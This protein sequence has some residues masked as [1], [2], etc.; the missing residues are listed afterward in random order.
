[1]KEWRSLEL[2]DVFL[3]LVVERHFAD[4]VL[5]ADWNLAVVGDALTGALLVLVESHLLLIDYAIHVVP[6]PARQIPG[7]NISFFV[8][9]V[10]QTSF[11]PAGDSYLLEAF[12]LCPSHSCLR[13]RKPSSWDV[14]P[15]CC[16]FAGRVAAWLPLPLRDAPGDPAGLG[17][18]TPFTVSPPSTFSWK[19]RELVGFGSRWVRCRRLNQEGRSCSMQNRITGC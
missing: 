7:S 12:L 14:G 13:W 6:R 16:V 8:H 9:A 3:L 17:S 4:G 18:D 2:K 10:K 1:M 19:Q 15:S 11:L 5:E